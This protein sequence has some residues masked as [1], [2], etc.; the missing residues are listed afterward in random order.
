MVRYMDTK[1]CGFLQ[2]NDSDAKGLALTSTVPA[3]IRADGQATEGKDITF[4]CI[5]HMA[6]LQH[7]IQV[8][9]LLRNLSQSQ[10]FVKILKS[11]VGELLRG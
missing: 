9:V 7:A 4:V 1:T 6:S 11:V 3:M 2:W 5:S 8:T 10:L